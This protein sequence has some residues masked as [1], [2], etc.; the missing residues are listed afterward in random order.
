MGSEHFNFGGFE[1]SAHISRSIPRLEAIAATMGGGFFNPLIICDEHTAPIA[2]SICGGKAVPR[3]VLHSG[4]SNKNWTAVQAILR[5]ARDA[6]LGRDGIFI[7]AGGGVTGDL[8]AF[9]ASI[10]MRGCALALVS[11]TLLGMVDASLGGK[12]G[13]D[14]FGIKN[15][16]GTFYPARHVYLPLE[17]LVTL[18][19][20]EWKSGMAELIK[21][22]VL[23]GDDFIEALFNI[24]GMFPAGSFAQGFPAGFAA[25]LLDGA[26]SSGEPL[27]QCVSR[28]VR[29]K[30]R[31]VQADPRETGTERVLLNLGHTFA[32]AL[33]ASVGLGTVSHG[34]AV[35][36][37]MV[38][39]CELGRALGITPP[40]RAETIQSL[41]AAF[42]YETAAPHPLMTDTNH[43][44]AALGGDK[45]QRG[46]RFSFIVPAGKS[47]EAV[48]I[49]GSE[50]ETI[51]QTINGALSL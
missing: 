13:F 6:G 47:A 9:A 44:L 29:L 28:A 49:S 43:F 27:Q 23:D 16:A 8:S 11:T 25:R 40:R 10:Y 7:G 39:S 20:A 4:E 19:G 31:I 50:M 22:A 48:F 32:H 26:V 12:T 30:G 41:I 3:C 36:W 15:L 21:T 5:A 2:D 37:G 46:G 51:K 1:S 17:S 24:A 14:L 34:E 33:E 45:K 18:P 38:R 35:A 42:G